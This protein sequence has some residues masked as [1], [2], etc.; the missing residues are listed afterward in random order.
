MSTYLYEITKSKILIDEQGIITVYG[1]RICNTNPK[2]A[3]K[4][5]EHCLI[6]DISPNYNQVRRLKELIE[7][8]ELFPVHLHDVV[9]DFLA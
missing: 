8:M 3:E 4:D 6:D 1:I 5:G 7:E 2:L 9:E